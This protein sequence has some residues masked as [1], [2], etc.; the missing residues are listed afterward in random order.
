LHTR[1]TIG[2]RRGEAWMLQRLA[3]AR[4]AN[5]AR[6]DAEGLLTRAIELSTQCSDEDL[7]DACDKLR[8]TIA[9]GAS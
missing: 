8:R 3:R 4:A 6:D 5:G 2:D 1:Q 7:M 9:G